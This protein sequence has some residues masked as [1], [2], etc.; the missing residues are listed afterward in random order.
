MDEIDG[1]I[2]KMLRENGR[3]PFAA[4][5]AEVGLSPH[6]TADRVRR[7]ER[8]GVI[9]GFT[10]NVDLGRVGRSLDAIVDA[11]LSP[12]TDPEKFEKQVAKLPPVRELA[13]LTGRFD[14]QLR[15]AC[16][17]SEE[18]ART[19]L[20]IRR[21]AGASQTETRIVMRVAVLQPAVDE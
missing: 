17:D 20:A 3:A 11:R 9:T 16:R 7:L 12:N 15:V 2:V 13:F 14:Y 6:G 8:R 18:L 19:V 10:A 5:G 21:D 1:K 4:I